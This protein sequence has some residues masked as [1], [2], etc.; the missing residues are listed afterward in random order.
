[1]T[2][3]RL[4]SFGVTVCAIWLLVALYRS[5]VLA[6]SSSLTKRSERWGFQLESGAAI[7]FA[8]FVSAVVSALFNFHPLVLPIVASAFVI[9]VTSGIG[10]AYV[11]ILLARVLDWVARHLP[12]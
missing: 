5:I 3:L 2:T 4:A 6:L 1:V 10:L 12:I 11:T 8:F 9:I 7:A